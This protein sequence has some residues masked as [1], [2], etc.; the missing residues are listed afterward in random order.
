V[1]KFE[2]LNDPEFANRL[3]NIDQAV[4]LDT[5]RLANAMFQRH[6]RQRNRQTVVITAIPAILVLVG[7]FVLWPTE[8]SKKDAHRTAEHATPEALETNRNTIAS[9]EPGSVVPVDQVSHLQEFQEAIL[10]DMLA[11]A[12]QAKIR[13]LKNEIALIKQSISQHEWVARREFTSRTE[14]SSIALPAGL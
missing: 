7:L 12:Q 4:D 11:R 14:P 2:S 8:S 10:Q 3:R 9:A 1:T 13:E 5:D 6:Q